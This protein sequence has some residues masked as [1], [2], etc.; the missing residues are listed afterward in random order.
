[1]KNQENK[2]V[3]N[4]LRKTESHIFN[5]KYSSNMNRIMKIVSIE[6]ETGTVHY[7]IILNHNIEENEVKLYGIYSLSKYNEIVYKDEGAEKHS[8]DTSLKFAIF[9]YNTYD[10][11][12]STWKTKH[13]KK[14]SSLKE[15][16]DKIRNIIQVNIVE[17]ENKEYSKISYSNKREINK[18]IINKYFGV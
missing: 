2:I 16:F 1:M 11:I 4:Y 6:T 13:G 14:E 15:V 7:Q 5:M 3:S 17:L 8:V 10:A 18:D 12:K 9:V